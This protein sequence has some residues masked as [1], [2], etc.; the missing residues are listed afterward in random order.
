MASGWWNKPER[1]EQSFGTARAAH[2]E[3]PRVLPIDVASVSKEVFD[4][5]VYP[6]WHL[7]TAPIESI[8]VGMRVPALNPQL[9]RARTET[10]TGEYS[11]VQ[12]LDTEFGNVDPATWRSFRLT[13][14]KEDGSGPLEVTLLR[15]AHWLVDEAASTEVLAILAEIDAA[16]KSE[17]WSSQILALAE[18]D[19]LSI[20]ESSAIDAVATIDWQTIPAL[21][22]LASWGIESAAGRLRANVIAEIE[23]AQAYSA[24]VE[25]VLA[26]EGIGSTV[27]LEMPELGVVGLATVTANEPCPDLIDGPGQIVT[28]T[29]KHASAEVLDLTFDPIHSS[30]AFASSDS[31]LS[32]FNPQLSASGSRLS[33]LDSRL[34]LGVTSA[35]PFWSITREDFIPAGE[36]R[37]GEHV[38][39]IDGQHFRLTSIVPRAGPEPVYNFE[40]AIDHVYYV[41]EGGLLV[42]NSYIEKVLARAGQKGAKYFNAVTAGGTALRKSVKK[43]SGDHVLPIKAAL[44][45]L[46][47]AGIKKGS[48]KWKE[49]MDLV[50][51]QQNLVAMLKGLNSAKGA[52]NAA[53]LAA[54]SSTQIAPSVLRFIDKRQRSVATQ[55]NSI[56]NR[57]FSNPQDW[58]KGFFN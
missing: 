44:D 51:S 54:S 14:D 48:T 4:P 5:Q 32:T 37:M 47:A 7:K 26:G 3:T 21:P 35:H 23:G 55:I 29:F 57:N 2:E 8:R 38:I 12:P 22:N 16:Q 52:R 30:S 28:A 34:T 13:V 45:A 31:Q 27:W 56:I 40:V 33:S 46:K 6:N 24:A 1:G 50:H 42:H 58:F 41:G 53:Q 36:L 15:P 39:G 9:E 19:P 17:H 10:P 18:F 49:V 11:S 43:L 20:L 25:S